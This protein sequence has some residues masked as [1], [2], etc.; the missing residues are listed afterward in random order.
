MKKID[1]QWQKAQE[2]VFVDWI[3]E[4]LGSSGTVVSNLE[5]DM[6]SGVILIQL[7]EKLTGHKLK[8][9]YNKNASLKIQLISN[10][11]AALKFIESEYGWAP[12]CSPENIVNGGADFKFLLGLLFRLYY[13][14]HKTSVQITQNPKKQQDEYILR[15]AQTVLS[16]YPIQLTTISE[17]K[18]SF[19]NGKLVIALIDLYFAQNKSFYNWML[20]KS[21]GERIGI[22]LRIARDLIH[23]TEMV[24]TEDVLSKN[25]DERVFLFY[26]D[27]FIQAIK[28]GEYF[29]NVNLIELVSKALE[30]INNN[31]G[32]RLAELGNQKITNK[33]IDIS[34]KEMNTQQSKNEM[35]KKLPPPIKNKPHLL[36]KE[37]RPYSFTSNTNYSPRLNDMRKSQNT[38]NV[39]PIVLKNVLQKGRVSSG[40]VLVS[41]NKEVS[42]SGSSSFNYDTSF[43]QHKTQLP[44]VQKKKENYRVVVTEIQPQYNSSSHNHYSS[45]SHNHYSSSSH[46]RYKSDISF[47]GYS[48]KSQVDYQVKQNSQYRTNKTAL[49]FKDSGADDQ[50]TYQ[51]ST[52]IYGEFWL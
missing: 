11:S 38:T 8:E 34:G 14:Y 1:S 40:H 5:D 51:E 44:P 26:M 21:K 39:K 12:N 19:Y 9:K 4:T 22:G 36:E 2:L 41:N 46:N 47:S 30:E 33:N 25:I 6:K 27:L 50:N 18:E 35:T 32:I 52:E 37:R 3:N 15:W 48:G 45:S 13:N 49:E 7:V 23:I 43:Q 10:C 31:I 24:T 42:Y 28:L 17:L 29:V 16:D 20:S